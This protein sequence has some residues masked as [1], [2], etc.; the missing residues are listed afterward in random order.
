MLYIDIKYFTSPHQSIK[1]NKGAGEDAIQRRKKRE[2]K[3]KKYI[4]Q[5]TPLHQTKSILFF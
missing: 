4:N 5:S 1:D 3:Y 2:E